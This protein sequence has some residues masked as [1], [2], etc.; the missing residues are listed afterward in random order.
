M[1]KRIL[2]L[3]ETIIGNHLKINLESLL[4]YKVNNFNFVTGAVVSAYLNGLSF[5]D[6]F[7][8]EPF[9]NG[10]W[11]ESLAFPLMR[12]FCHKN[13]PVIFTSTQNKYSLQRDLGLKQ[14][15]HYSH[16]I[17]KPYDIEGLIPVLMGSVGDKRELED[18][19]VAVDH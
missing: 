17:Q 6:V 13:I 5:Y 2:V 1:T 8:V 3:D 4:G 19:A 12:D 7:L 18:Y 16:Y 15:V 9:L 14:G 11:P 10:H